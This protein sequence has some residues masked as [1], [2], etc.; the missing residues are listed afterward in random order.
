M[1]HQLD[2]LEDMHPIDDY[3]NIFDEDGF[4]LNDAAGIN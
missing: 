3:D 4:D 2:L 1:E